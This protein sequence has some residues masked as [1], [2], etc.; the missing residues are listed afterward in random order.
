MNEFIQLLRY[1]IPAVAILLVLLAAA[2]LLASLGRVILPLGIIAALA[3]A[4]WLWKL[5]R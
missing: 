4:C 1:L 5:S 2:T 3:I